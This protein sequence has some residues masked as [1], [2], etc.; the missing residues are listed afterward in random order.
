MICI[1]SFKDIHV[2]YNQNRYQW[3]EM[4]HLITDHKR[5]TTDMVS[6]CTPD[7]QFKW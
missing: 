5:N 2:V 3:L 4:L 6:V 1:F 7:A